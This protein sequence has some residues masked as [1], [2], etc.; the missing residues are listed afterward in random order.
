LREQHARSFTIRPQPF[1]TVAV[2][3]FSNHVVSLD[4]VKECMLAAAPRV[5]RRNGINT[6]A[7]IYP[8]RVPGH[9]P[10]HRALRC[11]LRDLAWQSRVGDKKIGVPGSDRLSRNHA[12]GTFER[13]DL[14]SLKQVDL[15]KY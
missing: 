7:A 6:L 12:A 5:R 9:G 10:S 11:D 3:L 2:F 13:T 4:C 1:F 15:S 14:G 8:A